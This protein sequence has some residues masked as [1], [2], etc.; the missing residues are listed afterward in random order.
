MYLEAVTVVGF[1]INH[2]HQLVVVFS[3]LPVSWALKCQFDKAQ[4]W[5]FPNKLLPE[6]QLLPAPPPSLEMKKFS[7]L[8]RFLYAEFWMALIT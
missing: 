6:A 3:P 5:C 4:G 2:I 1:A 7:G 8:Y